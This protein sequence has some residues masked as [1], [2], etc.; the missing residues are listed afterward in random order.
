MQLSAD[1]SFA[2]VPL[3]RSGRDPRNLLWAGL[4]GVL[5]AVFLV[6]KPWQLLLGSFRSTPSS[7]PRPASSS[8]TVSTE[9]KRQEED[10]DAKIQLSVQTDA[11]AAGLAYSRWRLF[12]VAGIILAPMLPASNIFFY[13]GTF[14]AE[15]LLLLPSGKWE[16]VQ[17]WWM[18]TLQYCAMDRSRRGTSLS[19]LPPQLD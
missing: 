5:A 16:L 12:V 4:Y 15:R 10:S 1:W 13:V 6:A 8:S 18:A 2:C 7:L 3:V 19:S 14:L 17:G 9:E 11:A